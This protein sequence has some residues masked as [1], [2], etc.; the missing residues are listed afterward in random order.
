MYKAGIST[1]QFRWRERERERETQR[2][3]TEKKT[4]K[5]AI[6]HNPTRRFDPKRWNETDPSEKPNSKIQKLKELQFC[7]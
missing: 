4:P 5:S 7:T 2:V 3:D 6:W 1:I